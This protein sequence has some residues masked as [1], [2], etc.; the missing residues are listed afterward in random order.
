MDNHPI[1]QDVTGFQ[2]KLIGN[3]TVKQFAYIAT[4]VIFSVILFYSP[5]FFLIK[6]P[7]ILISLG[8]GILLAF[9]PFEG[10]PLDLLMMH[11]FK[12]L[13]IP[14][15]Y[16]YQKQ[17]GYLSVAH[18]TTAPKQQFVKPSLHKTI[19]ATSGADKRAQLTLL[20]GKTQPK[21]I[22]PLDEK[23]ARFT[24]NLFQEHQLSQTPLTLPSDLPQQPVVAPTP[25]NTPPLP[26]VASLPLVQAMPIA[27]IMP[28]EKPIIESHV[29]TKLAPINTTQEIQKLQ[30]ETQALSVKQPPIQ[31]PQQATTQPVVDA[32]KVVSLEKQLA[33]FMLQ[34]Q[35]LEQQISQMKSGQNGQPIYTP[36]TMQEKK[37]T[38]HV[39]NVP[40]PL[41]KKVGIPTMPEAPNLIAGIIKDARGNVLP[42]ILV[43]IKDK[44]GNSIRAF[45]TNPLGQF[46]SATQ[47]PNGVYTIEF[48]DP[49]KQHWFDTVEIEASGKLIMPIEI[50]SHDA[51]EELR[52]ALFS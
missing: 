27:P 33:D 6:F 13:F 44:D 36:S 50:V 38:P 7:L 31:Q 16:V 51:R 14:N 34:K 30:Q 24:K 9:V 52:Q 48:D 25:S 17:G 20:L 42:S 21:S 10:R 22:T 26:T 47:L 32:T 4:P 35:H 15:Q 37:E 23:E 49:R 46:A 11:F 29:V 45:K 40:Q 8:I 28:V 18:M 12:A 2:F 43:D 1:P 5:L 3:M 41:T 19:P 39:R